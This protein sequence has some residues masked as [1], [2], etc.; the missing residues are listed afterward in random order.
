MC[1]GVVAAVER[2]AGGRPVAGVGVRVGASLR[3][4]PDA[5]AQSFE[6]AAAGTVAQDALVDLTIV[7]VA[8]QCA[9][10]GE[11]FESDDPT[12]ACPGCGSVDIAASGGDELTLE[13]LRYRDA[14]ITNP[15]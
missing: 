9:D 7:P 6:L 15:S 12:P 3:V 10:C 11:Q 2:R 8:A 13:W 5:F 4:V 14:P 1:E